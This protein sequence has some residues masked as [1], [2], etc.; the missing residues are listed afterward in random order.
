MKFNKSNLDIISPEEQMRR[1]KI[2]R[3]ETLLDLETRLKKYGRCMLVRCTGFG[4]TWM[5][6]SLINKYNKVLYLYPADVVKNTVIDRYNE[7]K[8]GEEFKRENNYDESTVENTVFMT[9]MKLIRLSD[10]EIKSMD[11]D[12]V[13]FDEAH[14]LGGT[15]TKK[16][17]SK[18]FEY[19]EPKNAKFIGATATP[20]RSDSFDIID[21]F[22]DN[23][24]VKQYT[25]HDAIKD[26]IIKKPYYIYCCLDHQKSIEKEMTKTGINMKDSDVM[27]IVQR[28][29]M[30]ANKIYNMEKI[31]SETLKEYRGSD[32]YYKFIVFFEDIKHIKDYGDK[33]ADWFRCAFK[34]W[35][36][37][38]LTITSNS[39]EESENV[40]K[41]RNLT[42]KNKHIDLIY[43]VD[44]LNMGYHI[45]DLTGVVMY[46]GTSSSI[47]F[48]QQLGRA[49]SSGNSKACIVFDVVDNL[50]RKATFELKAKS[51]ENVKLVKQVDKVSNFIDSGL[52]ASDIEAM[53]DREIISL[54][55]KYAYS[56]SGILISLGDDNY[57]DIKPLR[58]RLIKLL[59]DGAP[60]WWKF[61]NT[62][63]KSDV[64][65]TGQEAYYYE[66]I[67]KTC[68]EPLA[69]RARG[70]LINH[71]IVYMQLRG[72]CESVYDFKLYDLRA[73][74]NGDFCKS[75]RKFIIDND[76][77]Y[78]FYN[79]DKFIELFLNNDESSILNIKRM[80]K[81]AGTSIERFMELLE[82]ANDEKVYVA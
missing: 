49:L 48:N 74:D 68:A 9:Y 20:E 37:S 60:H 5:L 79:R 17:V 13:I 33:V 27:E 57:R 42:Y 71:L 15:E 39:K 4:K 21:E 62:I 50:H 8:L 7:D 36:L 31:I 63:S 34:D 3:E 24:C 6:T 78:P 10:E 23:V 22:F 76:I 46:R 45:N 26:G 32:T 81:S 29:V 35:S 44:M 72:M 16:S 73:L 14:K 51:R 82:V 64:T 67:A 70:A 30:Y 25:L 55:N 75:L 41:L 38:T 77:T 43:C 54:Y 80:I 2:R 59:E 58:R 28:S 65:L 47:I 61:C 53:S 11:F 19:L 18:I 40:N 12:L 56:G 69:Y 52:T 1:A 66:F